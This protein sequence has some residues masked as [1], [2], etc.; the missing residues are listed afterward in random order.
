M[1]SDLLICQIEIKLMLH[2]YLLTSLISRHPLFAIS[3]TNFSITQYLKKVRETPEDNADF[4]E[5]KDY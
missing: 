2:L 5:Y 1:E 3:I 4:W